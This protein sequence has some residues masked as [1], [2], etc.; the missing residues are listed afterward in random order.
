MEV[1]MYFPIFSYMVQDEDQFLD[2]NEWWRTLLQTELKAA[3]S[4]EAG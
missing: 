1:A 4:D 3:T 2:P